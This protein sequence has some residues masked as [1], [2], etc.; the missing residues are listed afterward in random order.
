[1]KYIEDNCNL[2]T[3]EQIAIDLNRTV[4]PIKRYIQENNL[5]SQEKS[6]EERDIIELK[7]KLRA[8]H[9]WPHIVLEFSEANGELE[10]FENT[11]CSL[12]KQ[13]REDVTATE[14]VQ[15]KQFITLQILM[16][17]SMKDR[18]AHIENVDRLQ[19]VLNKELMKPEANQNQTLI[20]QL[21]NQINALRSSVTAYTKEQVALLDKS[22][23]I[24]KDMKGTR[25]QR[26]KRIE[27][28]KDS[29]VG[30]LK[31]LDDEAVREREGRQMEIMNLAVQKVKKDMSEYH[32][33]LDGG[34]D[35]PF[36]NADTIKDDN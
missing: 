10:Y 9:F 5:V 35:Q 13:F 8:K 3:L 33:Y 22:Q 25:D 31:I 27:D 30:L 29:W 23:Q 4:E 1:M 7:K 17:R 24:S 21:E 14:E 2:M 34:V 28:G 26:L 18:T 32:T 16:H 15:I 36:L 12:I 6:D 19:T 11:W 20:Q